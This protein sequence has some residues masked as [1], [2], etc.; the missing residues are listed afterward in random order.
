MQ[1]LDEIIYDICDE[2]IC[3][4]LSF[5]NLT[6]RLLLNEDFPT[7]WSSAVN[8]CNIPFSQKEKNI[9]KSFGLSLG[10]SDGEVQMDIVGYY[11]ELFKDC[12]KEAKYKKDK[13]EKASLLGW[14][15][16]GV[17]LMIIFL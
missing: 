6:Q 16:C 17:A 3:C 14:S 2:G 5:I 10:K 7:A 9:I 8:S 13:Y 15:L 12:A 4:N 1:P 11:S